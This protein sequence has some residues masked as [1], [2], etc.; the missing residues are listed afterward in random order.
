MKRSKGYLASFLA[1][2]LLFSVFPV[3]VFGAP[4]APEE[5]VH[6]ET[7]YEIGDLICSEEHEHSADCF[8]HT[9]ICGKE[10]AFAVRFSSVQEGAQITV[11]YIGESGE[12]EVIEPRTDEAGNPVANR[13][14]LAPGEYYWNAEL[15][16]YLSSQE[17]FTVE[18]AE[19]EIIIEIASLEEADPV[20]MNSLDNVLLSGFDEDEGGVDEVIPGPEER[21]NPDAEGAPN[22]ET[23]E[24]E[25]LYAE[26]DREP[27]ENE[28]EVSFIPE[29]DNQEDGEGASDSED[30]DEGEDD[31]IPGSEEEKD[32]D[33]EV[34]PGS[35]EEDDGNN[36]PD[37]E[38]DEET[39]EKV[40]PDSG[41]EEKKDAEPKSEEDR[42]TAE[43]YTVTFECTPADAKITV[44]C[45]ENPEEIIEPRTGE[46]GTVVP[47]TYDL[48]PGEYVC[49]AECE[50]YL[51]AQ[52]SFAVVSED[53]SIPVTL[54]KL[55]RL[56][57]K[58]MNPL[59]N[60]PENYTVTFDCSPTETVITVSLNG[61]TVGTPVEK[62]YQLS[63]G[64]YKWKAECTG[65]RQDQ[66]LFTVTSENMRIPVS[67]NSG[68][69]FTIQNV[70][71]GTGK[72]VVVGGKTRVIYCLQYDYL[73]P[74]PNDGE[75][76]KASGVVNGTVCI[77]SHH[78]TCSV[79]IQECSHDIDSFDLEYLQ[80]DLLDI[81]RKMIPDYAE[82]HQY[83]HPGPIH[84]QFGRYV[85]EP[86]DFTSMNTDG[87][88][89]SC[90]FG[91]SET[92]TIKDGTLD[93]GEFAHIYFVD[94]DHVRARHRQLNVT[95]MGTAEDLQEDRK[96]NNGEVIDTLRKFTDEEKAYD[97]HYQLQQN[98]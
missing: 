31:V 85:G 46:E 53:Q 76:H 52:G 73:W 89:R 32:E 35:E 50:E 40:T 33:E 43:T 26:V 12:E 3:S 66:G 96:W 37:P 30:D 91:R 15:D 29:E 58:S 18:P 14:I 93:G 61:T 7:C 25:N 59:G 16:G 8:E 41:E 13:Y 10:E 11:T 57:M 80:H 64:E 34:I 81:M 21:N 97:V 45:A 98:R 51:P 36:D 19:K 17:R 69:T 78:T 90:F 74:T 56:M 79:I 60:P 68:E 42:E 62:M 82:E 88:L 27:E 65:Y 9:Q 47:N 71:G 4:R 23:D 63:P 92:M 2:I 87:H 86:G 38:K 54:N 22:L 55:P 72:E 48:A 28:G 1:V 77:A 94:W 70:S 44:A 49:K 95:V 6:T 39:D 84:A 75:Y 5:H 83:R 67:L 24:E 20:M